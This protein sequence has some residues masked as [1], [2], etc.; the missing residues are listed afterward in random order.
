MRRCLALVLA[1]VA[2]LV[3]PLRASAQGNIVGF[4]PLAMHIRGESRIAFTSGQD[5]SSY[6][7]VMN[8]D[9]SG[10]TRLTDGP[11]HVFQHDLNPDLSTDGSRIVFVSDR[12]VDYREWKL[13]VMNVDGTGLT[14]ITD[15]IFSD[16]PPAWSP[17]GS[18]IAFHAYLDANWDI[19]V[20]NA[21]GTGLTRLTHEPSDDLY[22][23]WSPDG[24]RIVFTAIRGS[25]AGLYTIGADGSNPTRL[26]GFPGGRGAAWSPDGSRIAFTSYADQEGEIYVINADGTGLANLTNNAAGDFGPCWS[27]GGNKIA[28]VSYRGIGASIYVMNADGTGQTPLPGSMGGGGGL[29]W[30]AR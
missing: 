25:D 7:W 17:D 27:P 20:I 5:G 30:S 18:R 10:R 28:F 13:Y 22:P 26:T 3:V 24:S 21:D 4:L 2:L 9:G 1:T 14:R 19:Y 8:E 23:D 29:S 12:D 11:A 6:I 16:S 15:N